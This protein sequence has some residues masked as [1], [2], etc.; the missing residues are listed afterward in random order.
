[1]AGGGLDLEGPMGN[2]LLR[3]IVKFKKQG[4]EHQYINT[5]AYPLYVFDYTSMEAWRATEYLWKNTQDIGNRSCFWERGLGGY[6][7]GWRR[8]LTFITYSSILFIY[9]VL[10]FCI[11]FKKRTRSLKSDYVV[12]EP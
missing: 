4:G 5:F 12:F 1:M 2:D 10:C 3:H 7:W 11:T 9:F 8:K 6:G